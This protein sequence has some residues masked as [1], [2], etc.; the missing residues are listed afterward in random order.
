[1]LI[2]TQLKLCLLLL[3]LEIG[4]DGLYS[5]LPVVVGFG[6]GGVDCRPDSSSGN[7][8]RR[9]NWERARFPSNN[10]NAGLHRQGILGVA[11]GEFEEFGDNGMWKNAWT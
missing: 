9:N 10:E 11:A 6:S 1:M 2:I 8:V 4:H 7:D 5:Q 3:N